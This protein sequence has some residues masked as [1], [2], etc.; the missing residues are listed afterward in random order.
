[1]MSQ[2]KDMT[3]EILTGESGKRYVLAKRAGLGG[4]GVVYED[5]TGKYMIKLYY[6]TNSEEVDNDIVDRLKFVQNVKM[7]ANFVTVID[8]FCRPYVG[9]V[10]E[11]VK[12]HKALSTYLIPDR[13]RSFVEWYNQGRGL[14]ER[15]FIGYV[16][17]KSFK[18]LEK[19]NLSYCDISGNNI[20]VKIGNSASIK[21]IDIDNIYIAGRGKASVLGTPRYIAPEVVN[22]HKNPDILSDNYSL[23]VILFE[24]L[25]VG[26]PYIDDDVLDGSPEDEENALNGNGEYVTNENSTNM[27][28]AEVVTTDKLR[29]LFKRCFVEGKQNRL[30]RPSPAE[31]EV[32]LLEASNKL[33]KCPNCGAWHFPVKPFKNSVCPWCDASSKPKAILNFYDV[34]YEGEDYTHLTAVEKSRKAVNAYILKPQHKNSIKGLYVF[35]QN[36]NDSQEGRGLTDNFVTVA[37]APDGFYLYHEFSQKLPSLKIILKRIGVYGDTTY[38]FIEAGAKK[39]LQHGDEIYFEVGDQSFTIGGGGKKYSFVRVA[40]FLEV[41][42]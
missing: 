37:G 9:Y 34:L 20:L 14:Y 41:P 25:R 42:E 35:P 6:P 39:K 24:L 30:S 18:D 1:M 7:P 10:M 40:R 5:E 38:E 4:Q 23:A 2:I 32:A 3:G 31:F 11:K 28:P 19:Q 22:R 8:I 36:A 27:L 12:D 21:M 17:A 29:S 16:L 15:I 26:H 33:I 13:K